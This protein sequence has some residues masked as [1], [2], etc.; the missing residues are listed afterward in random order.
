MVAFGGQHGFLLDLSSSSY[1][2]PCHH[3]VVRPC[4]VIQILQC[5][6]AVKRTGTLNWHVS[7]ATG[8]FFPS[9][10]GSIG[11]PPTSLVRNPEQRRG[12]KFTQPANISLT[13]AGHAS[14]NTSQTGSISTFAGPT[15]LLP[16]P[17]P[18]KQQGS[19]SSLSKGDPCIASTS[20]G[21]GGS[22]MYIHPCSHPYQNLLQRGPHITT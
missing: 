15:P 17:A 9:I 16:S 19:S 14:S 10:L 4:R 2:S 6:P 3:T 1:T 21:R 8:H 22:T 13:I 7:R 5:A 18:R 20:G 12:K 11:L